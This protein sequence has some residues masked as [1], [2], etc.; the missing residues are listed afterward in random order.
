MYYYRRAGTYVV[1][2]PDQKQQL[3]V[4]LLLMIHEDIKFGSCEIMAS[5]VN[6][7]AAAYR[8]HQHLST[9]ACA[10]WWMQVMND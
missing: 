4:Q 9:C 6:V 10:C 3:L 2:T 7:S 5:I 8:L 1:P